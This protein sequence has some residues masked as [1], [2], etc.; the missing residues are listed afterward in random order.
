[1]QKL[2]TS[3]QKWI[4]YLDMSSSRHFC[5]MPWIHAHIL[6][7]GNVLPCCAA[8]AIES[9]S[10][11]NI[12]VDS[13]EHIWNDSGF[14]S[15]RK[16]MLAGEPVVACKVC[17]TAEKAGASSLRNTSNKV[18]A[19]HLKLTDQT[20]DDGSFP[21]FKFRYYDVRFSN[22]CNLRCRMCCPELSSSFGTDSA[23]R[24]NTS[25]P[26]TFNV[27]DTKEDFLKEFSPQVQYLEEIY[28]AGGEPLLI[29]AHYW[30]LEELLRQNKTEIRIRYN[31]NFSVLGK[32]DWYAP[33]LWKHFSK[34]EIGASLDADK[35]R[36]EY[37]RQGIK[38]K[39]IL[40]NREIVRNEVP[41]VD[42]KLAITVGMMNLL[43]VP[44]FLKQCVEE[45]FISADKF[46][47]NN[48]LA[49]D[50]FSSQILPESWKKQVRNEYHTLIDYMKKKGAPNWVLMNL[51]SVVTYMDSANKEELLSQFFK[52][53]KLLDT[54]YNKKFFDVFPEYRGL[55]SGLN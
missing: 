31:T 14:K 47:T 2:F 40:E 44:K 55:E 51:K 24:N 25:S 22:L 42:F 10:L 33:A 48:L 32:G 38:W 27:Y 19:H 46:Y 53:T 45:N 16:K 13:L 5:I 8:P 4:K 21:E 43:H 39:K 9:M 52:E 18:F 11:G 29:D 35:E 28:F 49:P 3:I 30:A 15:M 54:F 50:Y 41:H 12:K 26:K 17:Y 20:N 1:M 36:I 37:I 6:P 7:N 23:K 34:I